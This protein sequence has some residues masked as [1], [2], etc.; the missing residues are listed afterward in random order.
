MNSIRPVDGVV[1]TLE[2]GTTLLKPDVIHRHLRKIS[3]S[4]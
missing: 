3:K 2:V 4:S 1:M